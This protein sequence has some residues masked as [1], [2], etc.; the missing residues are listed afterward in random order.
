MSHPP[1]IAVIL[2]DSTY[3]NHRYRLDVERVSFIFLLDGG[4]DVT[5]LLIATTLFRTSKPTARQKLIS[6]G[7]VGQLIETFEL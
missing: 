1:E 3:N 5:T 4:I 6:A 7:I 2:F